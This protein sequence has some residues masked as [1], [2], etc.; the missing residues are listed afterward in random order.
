MNRFELTGELLAS[1]GARRTPSGLPT[2]RLQLRHR[3]TQTEAARDRTV[4]L[5][6][7]LVAFGPV[8]EALAGAGIGSRLRLAG[9]IDRKGA[10]DPRPELHVTEFDILA[11]AAPDHMN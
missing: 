6:T 4:E 3:S 5:E 7:E 9:F 8:A 11:P 10:R 1:T 2:M